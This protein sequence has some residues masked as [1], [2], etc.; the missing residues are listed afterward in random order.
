MQK[1][2]FSILKKN[3]FFFDD[4]IRELFQNDDKVSNLG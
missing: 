3:V 4:L 2:H 1:I